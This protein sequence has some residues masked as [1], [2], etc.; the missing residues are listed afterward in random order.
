MR[1]YNCKCEAT[2]DL[3]V[4][5]Y[6]LAN[7]KGEINKRQTYICHNCFNDGH[8]SKHIDKGYYIKTKDIPK[9]K[10]EEYKIHYPSSMLNLNE[11]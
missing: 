8:I 1:C 9:K 5:I 3:D 7:K 10:K 2:K 11:L 6:Q 4:Y